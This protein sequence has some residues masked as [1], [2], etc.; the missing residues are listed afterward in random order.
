VKGNKKLK[1][2]EVVVTSIGAILWIFL[3]CF[4]RETLANTSALILMICFAITW[5]MDAVF[6]I[7]KYLRQKKEVE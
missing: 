6:K 5:S 7:V 2:W 1:L 4:H 3:A